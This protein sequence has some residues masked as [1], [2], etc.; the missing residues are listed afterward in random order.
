M[1][2]AHED[3]DDAELRSGRVSDGAGAGNG[4]RDDMGLHEHVAPTESGPVPGLRPFRASNGLWALL[5]GQVPAVRTWV[6]AI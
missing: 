2:G 3:T 6:A 1:G 4:R 5:D